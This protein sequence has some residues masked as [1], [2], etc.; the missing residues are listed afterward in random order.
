M[1]R[2][3]LLTILAIAAAWLST[4]PVQAREAAPVAARDPGAAVEPGNGGNAAAGA[5]EPLSDK[6]DR[7]DGVVR[8]PR[9]VDPGLTHHPAG[10]GSS[11]MPVIPPPGTPGGEPDVNPK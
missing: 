9:G 6:L 4:A 7:S 2:L 1:G 11:S 10:S 3:R 5:S 8:P